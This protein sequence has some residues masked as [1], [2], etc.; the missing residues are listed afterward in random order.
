MGLPGFQQKDASGFL[1]LMW[2]H[3]ISQSTWTILAKAWSLVR[4]F[5]GKENSPLDV[6]IDINA[7]LL[8]IVAPADYLLV[9]G[10]AIVFN[11]DGLPALVHVAESSHPQVEISIRSVEGIL[12]NSINAGYVDA[13]IMA[14]FDHNV[15]IV[16]PAVDNRKLINPNQASNEGKSK[17]L[18][19]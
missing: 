6:F 7:G 3:E 2:S 8:D 16:A 12:E 10:F 4:D 1:T 15:L 18:Q 11:A 9:S 14:K 19:V 13:N 5:Q 17:L